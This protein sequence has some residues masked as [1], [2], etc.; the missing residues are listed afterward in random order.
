MIARS[1]SAALALVL[2]T[3]AARADESKPPVK[4]PPQ[5]A[6][7]VVREV[8]G[9]SVHV[10]QRLLEGADAE[11]GRRALRVL[12]DKLREVSLLVPKDKLKRL[13]QV[14][15]ALDLDCPGL[16][17]MQ[18]HPSVDWL[19]DHNHDP[20]LARKVHVPRASDL[21]GL[22]PV[23][24]QPMVI[25]HELAHA[26]HDQVLGF[27]EPRIS[28]AW[29][30]VRESKKFDRVLHITGRE[31]K[32]YALTN[33]MEFFAEMTEAY[34]GTNDFYPFVRGE[35]RRDFPEIHELLREVWGAVP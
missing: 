19:K 23:N 26:Y 32:H 29:A 34:F 14:G 5:K 10:D 22:L 35:L 28:K 12:A 24:R 16:T 7:R 8:E 18:Y 11:L 17:S 2:L 21:T 25:L 1:L 27:D 6:V 31:Q 3:G 33:P 4:R 9:W 20:S 30:R 13:R 15:I